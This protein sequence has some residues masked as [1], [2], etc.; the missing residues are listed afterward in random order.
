MAR[1]I[2]A[3]IQQTTALENLQPGVSSAELP[4]TDGGVIEVADVTIGMIDSLP[5]DKFLPGSGKIIKNGRL[6]EDWCG[7]REGTAS[8]GTKPDS[9][10]VIKVVSIVLESGKRLLC[11]ITQSTFHVWDGQIWISYT[12][13]DGGFKGTALRVTVSQLFGKM[14]LAMGLA[15]ELWE[16][17]F[18]SEQVSKVS[19]SAR[20]KFTISF[21]ER[22]LVAN[23]LETVGGPRP[24]KFAWPANSDPSDWE[25]ESAG[26][27]DLIATELGNEITGFVTLENQAVIVRRKSIV[28]VTRQPFAIAPFRTTT[29]V[30]GMGSDLPYT[31][32]AVPGGLIFADSRTQDVYFYRPGALPQSLSARH[33]D[34][35]I[36]NDLYEDLANAQ[37]AEATFN[38]YEGEYHLGLT[39]T[40]DNTL[41]TRRWICSIHGNR[42]AWSYDD[43]PPVTTLGVVLPP[44]TNITSINELLGTIDGLS[45]SIDSLSSRAVP[46]PRLYA[47]T[48]TGEVI[49]FSFNHA[50]D[51]DLTSFEFLF[52]SQNLGSLSRRRTMKDLEVTCSIPVTGSVT[53]EQSKDAA[54]WTNTKTASYTGASTLQKVRLPKTQITGDDLFWR[55]RA[56]ASRFRFHSWWTR[57]MEKGLQVGGPQ[58]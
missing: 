37:Y 17:D 16:V 21:A 36:H 35:H 2:A 15:E 56:T 6:R 3:T 33:E 38:P 9:N 41:I 28:H 53:V 22:I 24:S 46:A 48:S 26:E 43:G 49:E 1:P 7:R 30:E 32:V 50:T 12:I 14:Y 51:Y 55:I 5:R 58:A 18:V 11:R 4:P 25:S 20:G 42:V 13:N 52:Q 23:L 45:G 31:T 8:I 54:T 27:E 39:W 29:V 44:P 40:N 10:R 19:G 34:A 47:G 57:I